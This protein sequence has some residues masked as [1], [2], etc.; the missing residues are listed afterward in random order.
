MLRRIA[1]IT[2]IPFCT[3]GRINLTMMGRALAVFLSTSNFSVSVWPL[4]NLS[5]STKTLGFANHGNKIEYFLN[6]IKT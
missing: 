3:T 2:Y 6:V 4:E 5:V 1:F